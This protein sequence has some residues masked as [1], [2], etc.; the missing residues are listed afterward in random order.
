MKLAYVVMI[1]IVLG[2]VSWY[3]VFEEQYENQKES[4]YAENYSADSC[5]INTK[6]CYFINSTVAC[7][8]YDVDGVLYFGNCFMRGDKFTER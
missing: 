1:L 4:A 2:V 6:I 5:D 7:K 3:A 8:Y